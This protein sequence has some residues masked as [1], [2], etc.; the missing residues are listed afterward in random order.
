MKL[1]DVAAM[2]LVCRIGRN[3]EKLM[4]IGNLEEQAWLAGR[5]QTPGCVG[6]NNVATRSNRE[7]SLI[8]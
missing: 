2:S 7:M 4:K 6:S 1:A 8:D 3:V 5:R